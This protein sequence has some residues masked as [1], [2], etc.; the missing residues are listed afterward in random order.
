MQAGVNGPFA[1]VVKPDQ[2]VEARPLTVG[3]SVDGFTIIE[4]GLAPGEEV[5]R[6]GQVKL[7][8]GTKISA[9]DTALPTAS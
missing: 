1:Y 5:V 7:E 2:T 4:R 9:S 3:P 8:P 6:E